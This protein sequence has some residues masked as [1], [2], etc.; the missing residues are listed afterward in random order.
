MSWSLKLIDLD[1]KES[2][3]HSLPSNQDPLLNDFSID[4]R[5]RAV[6]TLHDMSRVEAV[7]SL[8]SKAVGST[9]LLSHQNLNLTSSNL[10][11]HRLKGETTLG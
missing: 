6:D 7:R 1:C 2:R 3:Y 11:R 9:E 10:L 8:V 4:K 5:S